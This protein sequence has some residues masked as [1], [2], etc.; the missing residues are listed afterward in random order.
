MSD[1]TVFPAY[2]GMFRVWAFL[3]SA[4]TGFPRIRG[5]VPVFKITTLPSA[6]F[7]PHTRGCSGVSLLHDRSLIVFPAYAG[8]FR[9]VERDRASTEGFPRI[10]GDVPIQHLCEGCAQ[11]FS[12]HTRGCSDG[13]IVW[14]RFHSVFPAY[15]GMFRLTFFKTL[16]HQSFPRIRGDVP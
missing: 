10:R 7:S 5:D 1:A 14:S 15:A 8:M 13:E 16:W 6:G 4:C 11:R 2:A 12:P 9:H 3:L